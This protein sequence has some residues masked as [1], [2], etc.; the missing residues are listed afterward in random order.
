MKNYHLYFYSYLKDF[1]CH[2]KKNIPTAY[3]QTYPQLSVL[4]CCALGGAPIEGEIKWIRTAWVGFKA[5]VAKFEDLVRPCFKTSAASQIYHQERKE[6]GG[7]IKEIQDLQ[8]MF[9]LEAVCA[10][11]HD[12]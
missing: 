11:C 2:L 9:S 5:E 8:E 6:T 10:A 7:V 4:P 3:P 1:K 12:L